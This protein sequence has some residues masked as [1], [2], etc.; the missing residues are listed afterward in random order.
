[1]SLLS[2]RLKSERD[3]AGLTQPEL[4]QRVGIRQSFIGA[5]ETGAQKNS[6]FLP[7]IAHALGVDAYWLKTGKGNK[8]GGRRLSDEQQLIVDALPLVDDG[9]RESWLYSAR[10]ALARARAEA[11]A[12]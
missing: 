11:K 4:A 7:E 5:L 8:H 6:G 3:R 2:E 1:M 9:V 12:A 10:Q